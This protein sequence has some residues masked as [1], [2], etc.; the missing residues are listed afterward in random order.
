MSLEQFRKMFS[1]MKYKNA[2]HKG[3]VR[4]Y[5]RKIFKSLVLET[6]RGRDLYVRAEEQGGHSNEVIRSAQ[7]D[8]D[9]LP[10]VQVNAFTGPVPTGVGRWVGR[11][12][13]RNKRGKKLGLRRLVY[14]S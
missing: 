1:R 5:Q 4:V 2:F 13:R 7:G 14:L 8:D 11:W 10:A 9:E 6:Q 12:V 3:A